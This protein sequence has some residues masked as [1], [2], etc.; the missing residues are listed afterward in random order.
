MTFKIVQKTFE[1]D[2]N[3]SGNVDFTAPDEL[4]GL[5]P[6]GVIVM[7][8]LHNRQDDLNTSSV[9]YGAYDGSNQYQVGISGDKTS[10][11]HNT[12]NDSVAKPGEGAAD[13]VFHNLTASALIENGVRLNVASDPSGGSDDLITIIFFAGT[14]MQFECGTNRFDAPDITTTFAPEA[15]FFH[16]VNCILNTVR[17]GQQY[18]NP[19]MGMAIKSGSSVVQYSI[20]CARDDSDPT[21]AVF[22]RVLL[23]TAVIAQVEG[24]APSVLET[25][26]VDSF[27]TL[28]ISLTGGAS[29][30]DSGA[31]IFGWV[32]I[33]SGGTKSYD[34]HQLAL[35]QTVSS[36][37]AKTGLSFKPDYLFSIP[38][39][40]ITAASGT[41]E[42]EGGGLGWGFSDGGNEGGLIYEAESDNGASNSVVSELVH[43]TQFIDIWEVV[44][45]NTTQQAQYVVQSIEDDGYTL[46]VEG[47]NGNSESFQVPTLAI[48]E[49][50]PAADVTTDTQIAMGSDTANT[51]T[52]NQDFVANLGGA[53]PKGAIIHWARV[54]TD[55]A[56]SH[57]SFGCGLV[58]T[59]G[60][61]RTCSRRWE[62]G[63]AISAPAGYTLQTADRCIDILKPDGL[64]SEGIAEFVSW[65]PN[66]IRVN[67]TTAPPSG[68]R[69]EVIFFAGSSVKTAARA[70]TYDTNRHVSHV[71]ADFDAGAAIILHNSNPSGTA[72]NDEQVN[73][74]VAFITNESTPEIVHVDQA[75]SA[76]GVQ[77]YR[78]DD[79]ASA[80]VDAIE[81]FDGS[82]AT[83]MEVTAKWLAKGLKLFGQGLAATPP[84]RAMDMTVFLIK[85]PGVSFD[86]RVVSLTTGTGA[87]SITGLG[88][89]PTHIISFVG[90]WTT[91]STGVTTGVT[92]ENWG[93]GYYNGVGAQ[94]C[95]GVA[96][97]SGSGTTESVSYW[98]GDAWVVNYDHDGTVHGKVEITSADADGFT[99]DKK[100]MP[101]GLLVPT[102]SF[103]TALASEGS[104]QWGNWV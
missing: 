48:G 96:R 1:I 103:G 9:S 19:S 91:Q 61:G 31:E 11:R 51:S 23:S 64:S 47:N 97:E 99:V 100:T 7:S 94:R 2:T 42:S 86:S 25:V 104:S 83:V 34:L 32:A 12:N 101:T 52:G 44:S 89:A 28:G 56:A 79:E 46:E 33:S 38:S 37:I 67:W 63:V 8:S 53:T 71:A 41:I 72:E 73:F 55:G 27:D 77:R 6:K 80:N 70:V 39:S 45:N 15:A 59:D 21:P 17:N 58:D 85:M 93:F 84:T 22:R 95:L 29:G 92:G 75:A 26:A 66:G 98:A 20:S 13:A 65:I 60:W 35:D 49:A 54:T 43:T 78:L 30:Q 81:P 14:D 24:Q 82:S 69:I 76:L 74:G 62:D 5:T 50:A 87:Q 4:Q 57:A 3:A 40:H 88:F 102:L 90:K 10:L 16:S 68:W 36:T 18:Q